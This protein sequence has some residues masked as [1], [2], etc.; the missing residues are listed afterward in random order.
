M[1]LP[2]TD[3]FTAASDAPLQ[4]YS[5]NWTILSGAF[6]VSA[7]ADAV[8]PSSANNECGAI[9]NDETFAADQYA[10]AT[11]GNV[12]GFDDAAVGV[13]VRGSAG[14]NYYGAYY[15]S[16]GNMLYLFKMSAA[17]GRNLLPSM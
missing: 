11:L 10:Q 2:A 16:G 1:A 14:G 12:A 5:A 8:Y 9:R 4:T 13:A 7:A 6:T 17:R 3:S 15:S